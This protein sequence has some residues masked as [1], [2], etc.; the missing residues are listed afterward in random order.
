M[1]D[2]RD[3]AWLAAFSARVHGIGC[4]CRAH[5]RAW[6]AAHPPPLRGTAAEWFGWT[7]DAH[8]A[9]NGR[10]GKAE[11]S[12]GEAYCIW[13]V[14]GNGGTGRTAGSPEKGGVRG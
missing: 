10:L 5:W 6:C 9:V 8:N 13:T 4:N 11:I 14:D 12:L 3:V 1:G 2:E 7:V